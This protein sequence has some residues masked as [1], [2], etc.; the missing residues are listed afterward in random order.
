ME[1]RQMEDKSVF[2]TMDVFELCAQFHL[3]KMLVVWYIITRKGDTNVQVRLKRIQK[4]GS[5][6]KLFHND[7]FSGQIREEGKEYS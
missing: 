5:D 4:F 3:A 2:S 6:S 1:E 7:L